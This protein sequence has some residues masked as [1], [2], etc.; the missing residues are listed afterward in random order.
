[1]SFVLSRIALDD[2]ESFPEAVGEQVARV[3]AASVPGQRAG[4]SVSA[5]LT[6]FSAAANDLPADRR[7][8]RRQL[9]SLLNNLPARLE[10]CYV[11]WSED[12]EQNG[13]YV[14]GQASFELAGEGALVSAFWRFTGI[15][16]ALVGRRRT[17]RR[18]V[19]AYLRDRRSGTEARD[20]RR[21]I[22]S[23]DFS[24]LT[25]LGLVWLPSG[26]SDPTL[27]AFSSLNTTGA[28]AG[29][30]SSSIQA[31]INP[32]NLA[33]IS[34][35][36]AEAVRNLGDVVVY[37][38][39]GAITAP[40]TGPDTAWEEV[41]GP[42]WESTGWLAA[43]DTPVLDNSL[44]R[45]RFDATNTDGFAID[46]WSGSAWVEQ[47]KMLVYREGDSSG[48]CDTLVSADVVEWSP[49]R[50]VVHAVMRRAADVYSRE[51]VYLTLQRGWTGPR[52]EMYPAR[53]STGSPSGAYL[54]LFSAAAAVNDSAAK[55]D[56]SSAAIAATAGSGSTVMPSAL[57]GAA[58]FTG[59]NWVSL[60]RQG[61]SFAIVLA[62]LQAGA[63]GWADNTAVAYGSSRNGVGIEH[64]TAGYVSAQVGMPAL[65]ADQQLE[66]ESMTLG[67]GTSATA[68]GGAS[69]GT[70]AT[71]TRTAD[72]IHV[73]KA[74]W[75]GG[76]LAK[77]RVFARVKTS[78]STLNI[79]AKTGATTG[80]TKT[81][82]STS[83]VWLD[84]G[85]IVANDSTL[86]IHC[87]ASAA[88]TVSVD[89]IEAHKVE[90]RTAAS[91]VYDGARDLGQEVLYDSRSPQTIVAR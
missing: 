72:A 17:H 89:R 61:Q 87:W 62:A 10:G 90:D 59:E 9:R 31:A 64:T 30:G 88:A 6:S 29:A 47:G 54:A 35:E 3:G 26:I 20:V 21:R 70:A 14:P 74:T 86:E 7:R 69:G 43:T 53:K 60:L 80:A 44:C 34:F 83:Y 4:L 49:H 8:V 78:A 46:R 63:G 11:A 50:A 37:D 51:D 27:T 91:P 48:Y 38:R 82:S 16:L 57:V 19:E 67:S 79:Y 2:P 71:S 68:D 77:Y 40:S 22:Y 52:V 15:E 75:P 55:Q 18:G 36:Q 85:D 41:Y 5:G 23:T 65:L 1:M 13:W 56:A 25:P 24:G 12:P 66:A 73:S 58:T 42:D 84:L 81:T 32:A 33:V 76:Q 45:V 28:R 39:R